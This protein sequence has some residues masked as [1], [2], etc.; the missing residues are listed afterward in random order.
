MLPLGAALGLA[1]ASYYLGS[2]PLRLGD[3]CLSSSEE[4]LQLYLLTG[5]GKTEVSQPCAAFL[6]PVL[7]PCRGQL[8]GD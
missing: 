1:G 8:S 6:S 2:Y 7:T 4:G 5:P 3:G